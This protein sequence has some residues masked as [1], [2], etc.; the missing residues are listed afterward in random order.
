MRLVQHF[1][2]SRWLGILLVIFLFAESS[3]FAGSKTAPDPKDQATALGVRHKAIV[4]LSDG[5]EVKGKIA[6]IDADSVT[7]DK[8]KSKGSS[9]LAYADVRRIRRDGMS[10]KEKATVITVTAVAVVGIGALIAVS[11]WSRGFCN[12]VCPPGSS[13]PCTCTH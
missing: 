12:Q 10:G 9:Q 4:T 6:A 1:S 11:A 7:I 13:S 3:S 8:G 5:S 2:R